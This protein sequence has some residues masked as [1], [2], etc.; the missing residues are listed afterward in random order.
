MYVSKKY[1]REKYEA[2]NFCVRNLLNDNP[3]SNEINDELV[4]RWRRDIKVNADS[5][6]KELFQDGDNE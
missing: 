2:L 3:N 1:L 6:I 5:I 4:K